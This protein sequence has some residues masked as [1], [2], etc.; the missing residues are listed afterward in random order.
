MKRTMSALLA[1]AMLFTLSCSTYAI[2][3]DTWDS[4]KQD[5]IDAIFKE[6]NELAHEANMDNITNSVTYGALP[7][8]ERLNSIKDR[9]DTLDG[10]LESLGVHKIDPDCEEDLERLGSVML[11]A[12]DASTLNDGLC[13]AAIE[14]PPNL[15]V[16]ARKYSL[17]Q[18][19]DSIYT[20][21][22]YNC[23]YIVV[24]D[25]KGY[26]GLTVSNFNAELCGKDSTL[27]SDLL[28]YTVNFG[29]SQF[30]GSQPYGWVADWTIGAVFTSLDSYNSSSI[31]VRGKEDI[32]AMF[33]GST[34]QMTYYYIYDPGYSSWVLCGSR[35][36]DLTFSRTDVFAGNV[37]G[38]Y[39]SLSE[40]F[41]ASSSTGES[42]I[43]YFLQYVQ[44][45]R[46]SNHHTL[47]SLKIKGMDGSS[48][49]FTPVY[50]SSP[51]YLN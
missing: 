21:K 23:S 19:N 48:A 2:G 42:A 20:D 40:D 24:V 16:L 18:Y 39:V 51:M 4:E 9:K 28:K 44:N 50:Y 8:E 6:L 43:W 7:S 12:I 31:V 36:S 30:L 32:Y 1:V 41:P 25:D 35:A 26:G 46:K 17:Y 38:K 13:V 3:I 10:Q 11:H 27:L 37:G 5:R 49:T 15:E 14:D 22:I 45:N 29:F 47:G 33:I 34:T